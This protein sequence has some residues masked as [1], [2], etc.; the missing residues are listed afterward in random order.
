MDLGDLAERHCQ[1]CDGSIRA[2]SAD[3]ADNL[4][5]SLNG[6][7]RA[8]QGIERCFAFRNHLEAMAFANAVAWM[9]HR[10]NHHPEMTIGYNEVR[11]RYWTHAV[12]GLTEND[13]ICAAKI[14]KLLDFSG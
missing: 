10:E 8:A 7:Q 6:W 1:A 4:L 14:E 2:L 11:V 13:F 5:K 12:D 3:A 9:A